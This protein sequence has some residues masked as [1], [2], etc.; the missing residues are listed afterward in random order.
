MHANPRVLFTFIEE[1][2]KKILSRESLSIT[3]STRDKDDCVT[4]QKRK[5]W[6]CDDKQEN[7]CRLS[8]KPSPNRLITPKDESRNTDKRSMMNDFIFPL[9]SGDCLYAQRM[10]E[11]KVDN[12]SKL[13]SKGYRKKKKLFAVRTHLIQKDYNPFTMFN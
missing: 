12:N 4:Q 10:I 11:G 6:R 9:E 7:F 2:R 3:I 5:R 1:L 8:S 13:F